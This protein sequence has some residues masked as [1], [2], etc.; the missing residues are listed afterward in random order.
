MTS[1]QM[2]VHIFRISLTE[3]SFHSSPKRGIAPNNSQTQS[4]VFYCTET[5]R[6]WLKTIHRR[7]KTPAGDATGQGF[8]GKP[9]IRG[10]QNARQH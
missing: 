8:S 6:G 7:A 5:R 3:D 2:H 9:H 4:A 10:R 1:A